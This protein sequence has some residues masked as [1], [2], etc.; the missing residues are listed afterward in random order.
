MRIEQTLVQMPHLLSVTP[1]EGLITAWAI[2]P[3]GGQIA[4]ASNN[5]LSL[6]LLH[7]ARPLWERR[8]LPADR[9]WQ[10][11]FTP[12]CRQLFV[13]S[14]TDHDFVHEYVSPTN[15]VALF[16]AQSG[17]ASFFLTATNLV[18]A[19]LSPG[20]RFLAT[21]TSD[22]GMEL[23]AGPDG[24]PLASLEGHTGPVMVLRFSR[25][26]TILASSSL[27][28]S[29][30]LWR[31]PSGEAVGLPLCFED[32]R[33]TAV[34]GDGA[35]L[36]TAGRA[37]SSPGQT[38]LQTWEVETGKLLSALELEGDFSGME[39]LPPDGRC[40][41]IFTAQDNGLFEPRTLQRLAPAMGTGSNAQSWALAP[42]GDEIAFGDPKGLLGIWDLQTG[43]RLGP[44]FACNRQVRD[45]QFIQGNSR[46]AICSDRSVF[47][48][49][50]R[51]PAQVCDK[52]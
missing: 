43:E 24:Q 26:E 13:S 34:S 38:L 45:I 7:T 44:P 21:A 14:L 27:D 10:L 17:E 3:D 6:T 30:R 18:R 31:V 15:L 46:L 40:L 41:M 32:P 22:F 42:D 29:V 4:T 12:D 1:V 16:D 39:F 52:P 50:S 19:I 20:G 51:P 36:A 48:M 5:D 28:K 37:A 25:D 11:G 23:R 47:T 33:V 2:S 8:G 49:N 35:I 9:I